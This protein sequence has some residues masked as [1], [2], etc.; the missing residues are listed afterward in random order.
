MTN[1]L[2]IDYDIQ[3]YVALNH[4]LILRRYSELGNTPL[5]WQQVTD[6]YLT[7][8]INNKLKYRFGDV[9]IIIYSGGKTGSTSL[10]CSF[11][12][13]NE[14]K[15]LSLH[16]DWQLANVAS[17]CNPPTQVYTISDIINCNRPNKLLLVSSYREPIGRHISSFF[18]N[19]VIHMKMPMDQI[20]SKNIQTVNDLIIKF[21]IENHE[22][23]HPFLENDKKNFDGVNIYSKTFNKTD[24]YQIFETKKV[25]IILLRFDKIYNWEKII[26]QN[27]KYKNF[28]IISENLTSEKESYNLYK[29]VCQS[30]IIPKEVLD[31]IFT[32]E[33]INM[34]YFFT[35]KEIRIIKNKWYK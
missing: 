5:T 23:Y 4:F 20:L 21:L 14:F 6:H 7:Y 15:V 25:K 32:K 2:P 35:P 27:T 3:K 13:V 12:T 17:R 9:E 11:N 24:G 18:Q 26:K 33:K 8:G 29:K 31:D 30:I 22:I 10:F 28:K 16:C 34:E 19:I 1:Q